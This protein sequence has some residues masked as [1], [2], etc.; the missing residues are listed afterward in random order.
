MCRTA[1]TAIV[2]LAYLHEMWALQVFRLAY[3]FGNNIMNNNNNNHHL[4]NGPTHM[5]DNDVC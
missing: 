1:V 3:A 5:Q 2:S 4:L